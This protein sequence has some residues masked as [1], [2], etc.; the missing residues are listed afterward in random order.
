M[1]L[2]VDDALCRVVRS[3]NLLTG[4]RHFYGERADVQSLN[5][6]TSGVG[7]DHFFPIPGINEDI[8]R[9]ATQ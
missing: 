4:M 9:L 1:Q 5:T 2:Q 6:G 3:P 8:I 7:S